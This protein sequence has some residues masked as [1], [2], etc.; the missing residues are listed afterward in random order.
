MAG[1]RSSRT[2]SIGSRSSCKNSA[3]TSNSASAIGLEAARPS[4]T[5]PKRPWPL[6]SRASLQGQ[7]GRTHSIPTPIRTRPERRGRWEPHRRARRSC[8][9]RPRL[10]CAR[11]LRR[12]RRS[13]S[14]VDRRPSRPRP[15]RRSS[16]PG[17]RCSTSRA[18][19]STPR[20]PPFRRGNIR[21]PRPG[22]RRSSPPIR[23]TA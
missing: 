1:S 21:K 12:A 22:S 13:N 16:A 20:S 8:T 3:R 6:A 7:G 23:T 17:W 19:S 11:R 18:S 14:E 4:R 2:P 9:N 15:D 10:R 5:S